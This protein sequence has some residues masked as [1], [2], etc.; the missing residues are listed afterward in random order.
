MKKCLFIL[1]AAAVVLAG[2]NNDVKIAENVAPAGS[3]A[4]KEIA[5]SPLSQ[6]AHFAPGIKRQ[7]STEQPSRQ[8]WT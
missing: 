8:P 3:N 5:F 2:C 6:K 1:A 4:Q 7:L